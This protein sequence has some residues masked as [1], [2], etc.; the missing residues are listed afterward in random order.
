MQYFF[1]RGPVHFLLEFI[2][3]AAPGV[4]LAVYIDGDD[5]RSRPRKLVVHERR[6]HVQDCRRVAVIFGDKLRRYGFALA[7]I[8]VRGRGAIACAHRRESVATF[9]IC[10]IASVI[11]CEISA[12]VGSPAIIGLFFAQSSC[13]FFNL[14]SIS[15]IFSRK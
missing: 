2:A 9:C 15:L 14:A 8:N 10:A 11:V 4:V 5:L 13:A 3:E 7:Q 12:A 6:V 1:E